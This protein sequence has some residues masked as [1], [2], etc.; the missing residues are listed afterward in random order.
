MRFTTRQYRDLPPRPQDNRVFGEQT[1]AHHATTGR[2]AYAIDP[3]ATDG[4]FHLL[5]DGAVDV[6]AL[7]Q[8][9]L[10]DINL[11]RSNDSR[12]LPGQYLVDMLPQPGLVSVQIY[13]LLLG[14]KC[15]PCQVSQTSSLAT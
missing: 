9:Q 5:Y 8:P 14:D 13:S 3:A 10:L 4:G 2:S 12:A 11:V 15:S 1:L 7:N 6:N